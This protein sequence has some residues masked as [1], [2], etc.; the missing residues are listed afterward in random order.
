MRHFAE[1]Q[2]DMEECRQVDEEAGG[3]GEHAST[4][5][6][7]FAQDLRAGWWQ[8]R[9]EGPQEGLPVEAAAVAEGDAPP[10]AGAVATAAAPAAAPAA[11]PIGSGNTR[12]RV[13]GLVLPADWQLEAAEPPGLACTLFRFQRHCLAWL[14]WRE[15]LGR[16][17]SSAIQ[18][19]DPR[20]CK[21]VLPTSNLQWQE[22][23]LPS[24]LRVWHDPLGGCVQGAPVTPPLPEVPGGLLCDEMGLGEL[25]GRRG[26]SVAL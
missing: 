26:R 23:V 11:D 22:M 3:E 12:D 14:K 8:A 15:S 20:S 7:S 5:V 1:L 19:A 10:A 6:G 25:G 2:A 21:A 17:H 13:F 4:A 9:S 24:G 16:P 18:A